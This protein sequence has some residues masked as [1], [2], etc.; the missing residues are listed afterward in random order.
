MELLNISFALLVVKI[1]LCILPG[2]G[3]VLLVVSS[4]DFK[5]EMRNRFCTWLFGVSNAIPSSKFATALTVIGV[6]LLLLSLA[7][8][9]FLLLPGFV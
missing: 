1:S 6:I 4:E 8:S 5:R 9:W 7:A 2:V 3:G